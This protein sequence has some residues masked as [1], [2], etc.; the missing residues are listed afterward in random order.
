MTKQAETSRAYSPVANSLYDKIKQLD[1]E[2]YNRKILST[3]DAGSLMH[4]VLAYVDNGITKADK[5]KAADKIYA[6]L[7]DA[8]KNN[9]PLDHPLKPRFYLQ[10]LPEL[11]NDEQLPEH[12]AHNYFREMEFRIDSEVLLA[13]DGRMLAHSAPGFPGANHLRESMHDWQENMLDPTSGPGLAVRRRLYLGKFQDSFVGRDIDVIN[14]SRK[15]TFLSYAATVLAGA[16]IGLVG[17]R[18]ITAGEVTSTAYGKLS[19][20]HASLKIAKDGCDKK[21]AEGITT[22][23]QCNANL[24]ESVRLSSEVTQQTITVDGEKT[25]VGQYINELKSA[26][27]MYKKKADSCDTRL[28][29]QINLGTPAS[30]TSAKASKRIK[31]LQGKLS[32]CQTE[33]SSCDTERE[34]QAERIESYNT[35][36]K[37]NL[38]E[39]TKERDSAL[40]ALK[41][42]DPSGNILSSV[43]V[44]KMEDQIKSL[45]ESHARTFA[46][47]QQSL[48][49]CLSTMSATNS[50]L[51]QCHS[52]TATLVRNVQDGYQTEQRLQGQLS[53]TYFHRLQKAGR[54]WK[55]INAVLDDYVKNMEGSVCFGSASDLFEAIATGHRDQKGYLSTKAKFVGAL[56][57]QLR[58]NKLPLNEV[59]MYK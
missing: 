19:E 37:G 21:V 55:K 56:N 9:R 22:L 45:R 26:K 17:G 42:K 59:C 36:T 47:Y 54:N 10:A 31:T 29:N 20:E 24:A 58:K 34:K 43:Y 11:L 32:D 27:N 53:N 38:A 13:N 39:C 30:K 7:E 8:F 6:I 52:T 41:K 15:K 2:Y 49:D 50:R 57:T 51:E 4:G 14:N 12:G 48:S 3:P 18:L 44:E 35:N 16:V 1:E 33:L 23:A 28:Q 46:G 25:T 5:K 40:A